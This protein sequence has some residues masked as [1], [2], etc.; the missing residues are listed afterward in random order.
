M[1][2]TPTQ[3]LL[4]LVLIQLSLV[5]LSVRAQVSFGSSADMATFG[6]AV[7]AGSI[8]GGGGAD[9]L[10]FLGAV[11]SGATIDQ[12]AGG[13]SVFFGTGSSL[14]GT[15]LTGS[16]ADTFN[17][18]GQSLLVFGALSSSWFSGGRWRQR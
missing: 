12:G 7:S 14:T 6:G 2:I 15:T 8:Y 3:S 5:Q 11:T 16:G 18:L 17:L 10:A 13:D 4:L 9:T 1:P